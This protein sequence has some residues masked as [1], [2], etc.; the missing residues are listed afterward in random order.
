MRR[1]FLLVILMLGFGVGCAAAPE[2]EPDATPEEPS[3]LGVGEEGGPCDAEDEC[4]GDLTCVSHVCANADIETGRM[5][6]TNNECLYFDTA[7]GVTL[8]WQGCP[9]GQSGEDCSGAAAD[10]SW[11]EAVAICENLVLG[12]FDDWVLPNIDELRSLIRGCS[13][14]EIGGSC[15]ITHQ[16]S[17]SVNDNCSENDCTGCEPWSGPRSDGCFLPANMPG[18]C[19]WF[20]SSSLSSEFYA[21]VVSF[22]HSNVSNGNLLSGDMGSRRQV[23]CV[24]SQP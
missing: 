13:I 21:Y 15:P 14:T 7:L 6:C 12:G 23:R 5:E 19:R 2:A 22:G 20:W 1:L 11:Q 4:L 9:E 24:R 8:T 3:G 17:Y 10:T 16:C 18:V